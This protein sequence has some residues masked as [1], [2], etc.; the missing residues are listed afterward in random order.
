[1]DSAGSLNSVAAFSALLSAEDRALLDSSGIVRKFAAGTPIM[2]EG[3]PSEHVLIIRHGCVKVIASAPGGTQVVLGIR[4]PGDIVGELA[5]L[6]GRPRRGTVVTID[7]VEAVVVPGTR[8]G[9]LL[10]E[11]PALSIAV[12]RV[13][14]ERLAESDGYRLAVGTVGVAPALARLVLDLV[15]RYGSRNDEGAL[16]L[17]LGLTQKDLADYLAVSPRTV[18]RTV[19]A[20][21]TAGVIST[22]RRS[23][24]V[25]RPAILQAHAEAV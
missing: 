11:R 7:K 10:T 24:V 9:Q 5:G 8:F 12:A 19:A 4:G 21:R 20:W 16:T 18:A 6:A 23:I 22:G 15:R 1:M 14:S 13:V 3:D 2:H 17:G 25:H